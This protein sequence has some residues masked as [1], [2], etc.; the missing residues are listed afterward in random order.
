MPLCRLVEAA[1]YMRYG[2]SQNRP[3]PTATVKP[4]CGSSAVSVGAALSAGACCGVA[5]GSFAGCCSPFSAQT[6]Q[7]VVNTDQPTRGQHNA[8][9]CRERHTPVRRSENSNMN[10]MQSANADCGDMRSVC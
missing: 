4:E 8:Q 2:S 9:Q 6:S 10:T 3:L 1:Q 5:A 7:L